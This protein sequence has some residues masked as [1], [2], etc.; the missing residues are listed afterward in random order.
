MYAIIQT[1]GK[2]YR[3]AKGD[4]VEVELL[5]PSAEKVEFPD[6]Y[7]VSNGRDSVV[8]TPTVTGARVTGSVVG[9]GRWPKILVFKKKRRKHYKRT[10]GHRQY[11]SAVRIEEIDAGGAVQPLP[12]AETSKASPARRKAAPKKK[13]A[14][15]TRKAAPKKKAPAGRKKA[16]TKKSPAG[17]QVARK[18]G[19]KKAPAARKKTAS[20]KKTSKKTGKKTGGK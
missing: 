3:V 11:Y 16:T 10:I 13:A 9:T 15:A 4:L 5:D 1:G 14:A 8:G 18:A 20:K 7:L 6:V 19:S 12:G 17:K 2:Q